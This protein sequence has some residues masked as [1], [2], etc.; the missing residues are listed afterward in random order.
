MGYTG[1]GN[2]WK[3]WSTTFFPSNKYSFSEHLQQVG[4][5]VRT[6]PLS[7]KDLKRFRD[8]AYDWA[9]QRKW[10]VTC[11]SIRVA[12]DKW[13][14]ICALKAKVLIREYD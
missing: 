13:E 2:R 14:C 9:W 4:D 8:A 3:R 10:R 12:D 7:A 6:G 5:W 1:E 11:K